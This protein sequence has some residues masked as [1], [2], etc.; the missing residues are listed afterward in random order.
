MY[1]LQWHVKAREQ[2]EEGRKE[3]KQ[4]TKTTGGELTRCCVR[5]GRHAAEFVD[6]MFDEGIECDVDGEGDEGE[7]GGKEGG[8]RGEERDGDVRGEREEERDERHSGC[9]RRR[10]V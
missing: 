6:L 1:S 2:C 10:T 9:C 7:E 3:R 5:V 4:R 8:E